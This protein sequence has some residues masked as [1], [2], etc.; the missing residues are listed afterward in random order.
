MTSWSGSSISV[1]R[2]GSSTI[3]ESGSRSS[4]WS[5]IR[6]RPASSSS[7]ASRHRTGK[8]EVF[9]KPETFDFLGFTHMCG[10]TKDGRFWLR[11]VTIKKR[12]RAKLKQVKAELRRRR[13]WPIPEQGRWLAS[14]LRGHFNYYAVPG[15]ID[16]ISAFRDRGDGGSGGSRFGAEANAHRMAWER[17][18]QD[19]K[20]V[21]TLCPHRA[22]PPQRGLRRQD[23]RQEPG[24]VVPHAGICP[25]GRPQGR[26][27]PGLAV[28]AL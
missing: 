21:A 12:L 18:R 24:A 20:Q 14:V 23:P 7:A 11:R 17:Y 8:S 28:K 6:T 10:K 13:H 4:T 25:G 9:R 26:S 3:F 22:S 15:N 2:S 16:A 1:M 19:R 27:L 5:C